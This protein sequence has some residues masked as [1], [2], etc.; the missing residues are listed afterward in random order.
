MVAGHSAAGSSGGAVD[1][2]ALRDTKARI[3]QQLASDYKAACSS[4]V[5]VDASALQDTNARIM[6][7]LASE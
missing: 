7:Q 3:M 2:S 4:G 5:T 6:Q 1:A